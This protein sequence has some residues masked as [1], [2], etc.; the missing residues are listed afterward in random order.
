[1]G[2]WHYALTLGSVTAGLELA[3][4]FDVAVVAGRVAGIEV[5]KVDAVVVGSVVV[6]ADGVDAVVLEVVGCG[7]VVFVPSELST[8]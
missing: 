4:V 5:N 1:M 2:L 8:C 6:L 3:T 7:M